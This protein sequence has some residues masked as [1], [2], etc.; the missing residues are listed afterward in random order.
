MSDN[1][2]N[3]CKDKFEN[4]IAKFSSTELS[5]RLHH[6]FLQR[7]KV[8]LTVELNNPFISELY[9]ANKKFN[10]SYVDILNTQI[11]IFQ[12]KRTDRL[13]E[14]LNNI[15]CRVSQKYR[16]THRSGNKRVNLNMGSSKIAIYE[17]EL[18]NVLGLSIKISKFEASNVELVARC[19]KLHNELCQEMKIKSRTEKT[20]IL[21]QDEANVLRQENEDLL[22]IKNIIEQHSITRNNGKTVD[23]LEKS[24][25][26]VKLTSLKSVTEK[27][28]WFAESYGLTPKSVTF[29]S[30]TGETTKFQLDES[31]QYIEQDVLRMKEI[32]FLLDKFAIGDQAYHELAVMTN[33][34]PKF[35]LV[36]NF[37]DKLSEKIILERTPGNV[38]GA[39]VC[40]RDE[41]IIA[42]RNFIQSIPEENTPSKFRVKISGDG[43]KVS[44]ISNYVVMSFVLV[45]EDKSMSQLHQTTLA[46]I[47]CS[48][49][50][51][52]LQKALHPL[53]YEINELYKVKQHNR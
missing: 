26:Y 23:E 25:R 46:I 40:F 4:H 34:L 20:F 45:D 19:K 1:F 44:R 6:D 52:N 48:E 10:I 41:L 32:L 37:R 30:K 15:C 22:K 21:L 13:E 28:L 18:E 39:F 49:N 47:K 11:Q 51:E 36:K 29:Q 35:Y 2:S 43:T 8:A 5:P 27:A 31:D 12:L 50:Y 16:T 38:P 24:Q 33:D 9:K 17:T 42:I 53:F 14:R 3:Y 7:G